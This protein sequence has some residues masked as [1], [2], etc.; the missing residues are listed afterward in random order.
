MTILSESVVKVGTLYGFIGLF[1]FVVFMV[2]GAA[3]VKYDYLKTSLVIIGL[4]IVIFV[5][6]MIYGSEPH[7]RIKAIF[8]DDYP[9]ARLY[10][11]Y[12]VEGRDGDIWIL[13]EKEPMEK[14][15]E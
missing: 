7:K 11:E 1:I 15:E 8:E 9:A 4:A 5:I 2:L 6:I 14:K 12:D 10:E 13:T 3:L